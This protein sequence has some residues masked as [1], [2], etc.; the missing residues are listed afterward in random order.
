MG[1]MMIHCT[2]LWDLLIDYTEVAV[3][4]IFLF[5]LDNYTIADKAANQKIECIYKIFCLHVK[6]YCV[7]IN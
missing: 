3:S 2:V 4:L 7:I 1:D 6:K 5:I